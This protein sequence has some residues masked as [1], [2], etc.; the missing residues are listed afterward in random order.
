MGPFSGLGIQVIS[1]G[2]TLKLYSDPHDEPAN[3]PRTRQRYIEAVTGATFKV[4]ISLH[5]NFKLSNLKR[6]DAVR[7]VIYYDNDNG[8][9]HPFVVDDIC[10]AWSKGRPAEYKFQFITKF[11]DASQQWKEGETI[12][13]PLDIG[14]IYTLIPLIVVFNG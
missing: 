12:F 9:Q 10:S 11:D 7:A 1:A 3:E 6:S 5:K 8:W 14:Q 13:S 4:K 2:K